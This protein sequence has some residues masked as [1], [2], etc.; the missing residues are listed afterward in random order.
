[1]ASGVA[2]ESISHPSSAKR[3]RIEKRHFLPAW[4]TEFPWLTYGHIEGMRC[5]YCTAAGKKNTF[6]KGC[7]KYKKDALIK[8][9]LTVD[10]RQSSYRSKGL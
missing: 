10:H 4:K 8:H 3:P 2:E 7:E 5:Q 1:M 6:T 9:V